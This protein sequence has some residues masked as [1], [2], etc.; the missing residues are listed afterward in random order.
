MVRCSARGADQVNYVVITTLFRFA[1]CEDDPASR[2]ERR[3]GNQHS[4][5]VT[6]KP[7]SVSVWF[8]L[9]AIAWTSTLYS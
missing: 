3:L 4:D 5:Q 8:P 6:E 2:G 1:N 9:L 7:S